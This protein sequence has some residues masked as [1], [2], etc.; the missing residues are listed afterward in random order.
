VFISN[1]KNISFELSR[2]RNWS[3]WVPSQPGVRQFSAPTGFAS[4]A[5]QTG[6]RRAPVRIE[7]FTYLLIIHRLSRRFHALR[8]G[9]GAM[10]T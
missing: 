10:T 9:A 6:P 3:E 7:G 1:R 8:I 2:S 4:P 5:P